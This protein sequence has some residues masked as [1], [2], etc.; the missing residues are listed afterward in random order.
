MLQ[1]SEGPPRSLLREGWERQQ[2]QA[3][4]LIRSFNSSK[5]GFCWNRRSIDLF[6]IGHPVLVVDVTFQIL[7]QLDFVHIG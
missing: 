2:G 5:S 6:G 3:D 1:G 7:K 4:F